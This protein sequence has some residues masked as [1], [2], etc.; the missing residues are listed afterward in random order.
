M[1][2]P[3]VAPIRFDSHSTYVLAGGLGGLGRSLAQ[4]MIQHGARNIVFLSR[5]GAKKA[6][7]QETIQKLV[8]QGARVTA[9]SCDVGDAEQ[10]QQV[11]R[12]CEKQYP[13]IRGVIQG[14]MVL[15][16]NCLSEDNRARVDK[17]VQDAI[18][19]NMTFEQFMG[20]VRPKVQGS[21]NL[22]NYL[23]KD[24]DFFVLLSSSAGITGSRGQGN[25][26]AGLFHGRLVLRC[27]PLKRS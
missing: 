8:K 11:L 13:P 18:Y 25:Y 12:E 4:W 22:H 3:S 14:A 7:A 9:Y 10:L 20:T 16:V 23:P 27:P 26:S 6:K 24:M 2:P 19:Q 15:N 5:S 1:I 17:S 21:W